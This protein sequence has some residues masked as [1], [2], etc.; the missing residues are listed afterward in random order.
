[1]TVMATDLMEMAVM[2]IGLMETLS[3]Y[4]KGEKK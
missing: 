2:E 3:F 1:M 4:S